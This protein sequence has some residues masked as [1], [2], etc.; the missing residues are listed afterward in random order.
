LL[1]RGKTTARL[2]T[3]TNKI[4][5]KELAKREDMFRKKKER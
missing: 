1:I 2:T 4:Q 3:N 5:E